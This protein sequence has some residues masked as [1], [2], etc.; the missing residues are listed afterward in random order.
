MSAPTLDDL[1]AV[2]AGSCEARLSGQMTR[3]AHAVVIAEVDVKLTE[4]GW[5]WDEVS[6]IVRTMSP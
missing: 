1:A 5:T 3:Q 4:N 2:V 6:A